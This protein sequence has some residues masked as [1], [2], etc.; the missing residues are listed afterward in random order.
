MQKELWVKMDKKR[1]NINFIYFSILLGEKLN[2]A[3][4]VQYWKNWNGE[5]NANARRIIRI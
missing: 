1:Y 2:D 5:M 3:I 4:V